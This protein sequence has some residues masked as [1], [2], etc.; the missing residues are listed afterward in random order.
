MFINIIMIINSRKGDDNMITNLDH[1]D[2][3][4]EFVS[5]ILKN[6]IF[7][8]TDDY[9]HHSDISC[10]EHVIH[11]SY[12]SFL[13]ARKLGIDPIVTARGALLHDFYLYDW[14]QGRPEIQSRIQLHGFRHPGIALVN[15]RKH[16]DIDHVE[17]DII[18]KHMW[19]LTLFS[20]PKYKASF[21]VMLV[22]SY[23]SIKEV[24]HK[25]TRN[26]IKALVSIVYN[27]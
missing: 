26:N 13:I 24:F 6:E 10:L 11:V 21:L 27:F 7:K 12:T 19:P 4:K 22:D 14:H 20:F 9:I 3:Y 1:L 25:K 2:K 23:C 16:F 8:S 5:D 18:K 17:A 15:A